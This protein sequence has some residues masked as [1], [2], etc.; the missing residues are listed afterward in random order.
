MTR[1]VFL[2]TAGWLRPFDD[3]MFSLTDA[4]S[5]EV[6]RVRR[7]AEAFTFDRHFATAGYRMVPRA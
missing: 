2:D 1:P 6:M 7:I 5:F 3:Q 4:V